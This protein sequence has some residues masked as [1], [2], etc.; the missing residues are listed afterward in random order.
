MVW[1]LLRH[2][3]SGG[4]PRGREKTL[5]E[6][7]AVAGQGRHRKWWARGTR[8]ATGALAS[9]RTQ[10][11]LGGGGPLAL[12]LGAGSQFRILS[13]RGGRTFSRS[14]ILERSTLSLDL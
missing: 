13:V 4:S 9:E 1:S 7:Q 14:L 8:E 6:R 12:T 5:D 3:A 10:L 2:Q 11:H